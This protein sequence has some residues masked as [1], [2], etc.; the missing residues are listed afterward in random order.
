MNASDSASVAARPVASEDE[1][2]LERLRL[3]RRR[4]PLLR[5]LRANLRDIVILGRQAWLSLLLLAML[6]LGSAL[7]LRMVYFPQLCA[8]S[9][10]RCGLEGDFWTA[11]Y[12]TLLLL[13]FETPVDFPSDF[14]GRLIFFG[15]PLL[16]LFFLLQSVVDFARLLF[17]KGARR[18][19]WQIS[20]ASTYSDHVIVCG[21]GRVGYRVVL[22]LLDIGYEVVAIDRDSASKFAAIITRLKVPLIVGDARD[23]DV[24]RHAGLSRA[25]GLVATISDDLQNVEIALTARR[26]RPDI[27]TVLRIFN[28][29]LDRNLERSFGRNSAF[30]S[31]ALAAAT[32]AAAA[33]SR[34]IIHVINLPER[35]LA[36]SELN[37]AADS[38]LSGFVDAIEQR[39][40]VRIVRLRDTDGRE[41]ERRF[42]ARLDAGDRVLLLGTLE[43]LAQV[44]LANEEGSKLA[45]LSA[46]RLP[47]PPD[48]R[49]NTVIVCGLGKVGAEMVRLLA[50][51][52]PAPELVVICKDDTPA[53][54]ID[55][56][57][58]QGVRII[59]GD[60]RD[61]A[62]LIEAGIERAYAVA[63]VV[64]DDLTNLQVGLDAR[65]L[66]P[67]VHL[68]LRVFSDV[69]AERLAIL[70]GINTTYST[71]ALAAPTLAAAAVLREVEHAFD[72]GARLFA[73]ETLC[74]RAGD[75]L[76]GGTVATLRTRQGLLVTALRRAGEATLLPR[77]DTRLI[78]GDEVVLLADLKA[79]ARLRTR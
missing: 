40:E 43:A 59:Q 13:V 64:S 56:L 22:Q 71:S 39:F 76:D 5:L 31:T 75:R 29:E 68:V 70:F 44:R 50:T 77:H 12:T 38:E 79:L 24:L 27:Q 58:R 41:R 54:L 2:R 11:L 35:L 14:S 32:F 20:L 10:E 1:I 52:H 53:R 6:L 61:P 48:E 7:Y 30:S 62:L 37:V 45:F 74:V 25:C 73:T 67:E 72:V 21:L 46:T 28:R 69:L 9:G 47:P 34:D 65:K 17:D 8:A 51:L 42:M 15:V 49:L 26:R 55:D 4:F 3:R 63:A 60:A 57:T 33:V 23:P 19:G 78:P 16:G 18:D 36:L 66:C